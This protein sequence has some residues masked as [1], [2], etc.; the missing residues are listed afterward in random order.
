MNWVG[1]SRNRFVVKNNEK[2]QRDFFERRKMQQKLKNLGLAPPVSPR[3]TSSGS[4]DLV[5]LFI[6]NQIAAKKESTDPPKVA[7]FGDRE[8]R[9]KQK[10]NG[11]LV[12][13]MSPCSPSQLSLAEGDPQYSAQGQRKRKCAIPQALKCGQFSQP[14]GMTDSSPWSCGSNPSLYQLETPTAARVIFKSPENK[15]CLNPARDQVTFPFNQLED[16]QP[17]LE[18]GLSQSETEQRYDGDGFRGFS[19]RECGREAPVFRGGTSKIY[20]TDETPAPSSTPQTVPDTQSLE[21]AGS[22][23][24]CLSNCAD[25]NFSPACFEHSGPLNGCE[26]SPSYSCSRGYFGSDSDDEEG[27]QSRL[28]AT[29]SN[30][31]HPFC[32]DTLKTFIGSQGNPKQ[33]PTKPG[34]LLNF[35]DNQEAKE[36]VVFQVKSS[37]SSSQQTGTDTLQLATPPALAQTPRSE[38]C[39]CQKTANKTRDA[40]TQTADRP[41]SETRSASTQCSVVVVEA[42]VLS[43]CQ[44]PVDVSVQHPATGG[45]TDTAAKPRAHTPPSHRCRSGEKHTPWTKKQ[46]GAG[47]LS[48]SS[49][50]NKCTDDRVTVQ[51]PTNPFLDPLSTS[52]GR[53]KVTREVRN[54]RGRHKNGRPTKGLSNEAT[55]EVT[56]FTGADGPSEDADTLQEIADILL[57]LKQGKEVAK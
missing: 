41:E 24:V 3:G 42:A 35:R 38:L 43:S 25:E 15:E 18:F 10:R 50:T 21:V 39:A 8:G 33:R 26:C 51:R 57:L 29:A 7:F 1:G 54:E 52:D 34:P 20:L 16:K 27:C 28:Q 31:D 48:G 9:P 32:A 14:R 22:N 2:K 44:P 56:S 30:L 17:I 37:G 45:Q 55:E 40:E 53:E 47:S 36:T 23:H 5:S 11:P 49:C 6:V 12:L 4:M 13:P 46:S 19:L